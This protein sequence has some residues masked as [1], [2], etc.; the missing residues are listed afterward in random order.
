M[1]PIVL[2]IKNKPVVVIGGGKVAARKIQTLLQQEAS[3]TV[4]S[5]HLWDTI[6]ATKV[7][8]LKKKYAPGD[9]VGA[10]LIFACTNDDS[11]NQQVLADALECQWVNVTSDKT[12]S[13]FYNMAVTQVDDVTV[14]VSTQGTAPRRAKEIRQKITTYLEGLES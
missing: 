3:V 11:V 1:Y 14:S 5:P 8:W 2:Q 4:V 10:A 7:N 13:E 12:I 9:L 6:D